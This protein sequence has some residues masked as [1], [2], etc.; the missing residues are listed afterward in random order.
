MASG[1]EG[2]DV[3]ARRLSALSKL[4]GGK[5]L[6]ASVRAG[7]QPALQM[8]RATAPVGTVSHKTHK[9]RLVAPGFTRRSVHAVVYQSR[10]KEAAWADLGVRT[11]AFYSVLFLELGTSKM[12]ARPWLLPAFEVTRDKQEAAMARGLARAIDKDAR[13]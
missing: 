7:I 11:E 8:A 6:A 1:L 2:V 9:G 12:A 5:A 13:K 4:E 10:D 3:L